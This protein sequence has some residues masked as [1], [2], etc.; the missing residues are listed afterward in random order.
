M[1]ES[2]G[3]DRH[4]DRGRKREAYTEWATQEERLTVREPIDRLTEGEK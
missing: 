3:S 2:R 1:E 4:R